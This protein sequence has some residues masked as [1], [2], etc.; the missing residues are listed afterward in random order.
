MPGE[1]QT[2]LRLRLMSGALIRVTRMPLRYAWQGQCV[3]S[4]EGRG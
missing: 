2:A 4:Y 3:P 1:K